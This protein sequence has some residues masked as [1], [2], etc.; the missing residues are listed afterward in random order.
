MITRRFE[1]EIQTIKLVSVE[2]GICVLETCGGDRISLKPGEHMV[3]TH[4]LKIAGP[5][6]LIDQRGMDS[7]VAGLQ[8]VGFVEKVMQ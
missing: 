4:S 7:F 2:D 6:F 1:K 3:V 5:D 8:C